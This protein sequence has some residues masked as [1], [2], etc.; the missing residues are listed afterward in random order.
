[1]LPSICSCFFLAGLL[2]FLR[3]RRRRRTVGQEVEQH[4]PYR[5]A[6]LDA[7]AKRQRQELDAAER[8][9]Y[10]AELDANETSVMPELETGQFPSRELQPCF[11]YAAVGLQYS[12][13]LLPSNCQWAGTLIATERTILHYRCST[14]SI[15]AKAVQ[16]SFSNSCCFKQG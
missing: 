11:R 2:I 12:F 3:L 15:S 7:G 10:V 8:R 16:D 14:G 5:K 4:D 6:E 9:D 1:M 13:N